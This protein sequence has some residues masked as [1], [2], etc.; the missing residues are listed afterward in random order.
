M[1]ISSRCAN[2]PMDC[3]LLTGLTVLIWSASTFSSASLCLSKRSTDTG[4][5]LST[6]LTVLTINF[7]VFGWVCWESSLPPAT[8]EPNSFLQVSLN[9]IFGGGRGDAKTFSNMISPF[10]IMIAFTY[11]KL[12]V[13]RKG[14][15]RSIVFDRTWILSFEQVRCRPNTVFWCF[16]H[17]VCRYRARRRT[18]GQFC[19]DLCALCS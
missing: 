10:S 4:T 16:L 18:P 12:G 17:A 19:L 13:C 14:W 6:S 1:S 8:S 7:L 2:K 3:Q 5:Q 15:L 9:E 11:N